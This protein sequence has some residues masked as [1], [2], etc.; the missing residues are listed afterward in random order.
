M[1]AIEICCYIII[2]KQP[3]CF[4]RFLC[5]YRAVLNGMWQFIC[6][7]GANCREIRILKRQNDK[8]I[9]ENKEIE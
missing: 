9:K 6:S 1:C 5:Y 7:K 3:R 4:C 8:K 2:F